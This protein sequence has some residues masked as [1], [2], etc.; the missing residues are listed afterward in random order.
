LHWSA[1]EGHTKLVEM[2]LSKGARVN[3]TNMGDDLP[4]HL[5]NIKFNTF[6]PIKF[7]Q[8]PK[9]LAAAH[10]HVDVVQLVFPHNLQIIRNFVSQIISIFS[11]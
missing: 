9:F 2:L 4:I 3:A 10:G 11:S 8:K 5:G 7:N 1:K 6:P